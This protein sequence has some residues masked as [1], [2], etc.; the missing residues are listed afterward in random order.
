LN[1]PKSL[2]LATQIK[3]KKMWGGFQIT[4]KIGPGFLHR[5]GINRVL[6]PH[7]PLVNALLRIGLHARRRDELIFAHQFAHF[8]TLPL[9]LLY[10]LVLIIILFI[11]GALS[12]IPVM[13]LLISGQALWEML[14]ETAVLINLST[15]YHLYYQGIVKSPRI[16]FW[17]FSMVFLVAGCMVAFL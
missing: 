12:V 7:P 4:V 11:R 1:S 5:A 9:V 17:G 6:I 2:A 10:G 15:K 13:S 14:A 3:Q 16:A 8:Q